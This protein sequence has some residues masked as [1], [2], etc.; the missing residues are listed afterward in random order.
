MMK[1]IRKNIFCCFPVKEYNVN[2]EKN[3]REKSTVFIS[4]N[5]YLNNITY[6][7]TNE[8]IPEIRFA[9]VIKVYDGDTITVAAK[10]PFNDSPVYRFSVRLNGIDSPEIHG[11]GEKER[12]LAIKS[13]DALQNLI[14]G[15]II[16]LKNNSK[17]KYGRLLADIYHNDIHVNKWMVDKGYAVNYD[18]G[19][20]LRDTKWD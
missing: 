16:E 9:K 2:K 8:F 4:N 15:E 11:K 7:E 17:E 19:K 12:N 14:L 1:W 18:G 5:L 13:R 10:L 3:G 6:K 20:K